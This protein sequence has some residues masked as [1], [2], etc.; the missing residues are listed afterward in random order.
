MK[1]NDGIHIR[2]ADIIYG[3][4]KHRFLIIVLTAAGLLTGVVLSGISYLRGEM[5]REYLIT[6][7]FS[8]NTQTQ[9]GLF[10]SGYDFPNYN[11]INMAE[12]L[13]DAVSYALK[14]DRMLN[15]IIDSL[16]LLG[17]TTKDIEDNLELTQ[18]NETQIIEVFLYWRSSQ[19][20]ID[21]L[22]EMNS[23]APEILGEALG[24]GNVSVI[25]NPTARYMVGGRINMI[26]WGYMALLGLGLGIGIILL[27][28]IMRP[29]LIN[30]QDVEDVYGLEILCEV[31]EDKAYFR[32][33]K[34]MLVKE[35]VNSDTGENFASAAHIIQTRLRK[36]EG[37]HI[38]YITSTLRGEGKTKM[39]ANLAI[40][41]SDLEKHVLLI[42]FDMKNP[43]LGGLFL[44]NVEYEH[45]LN[46]LY[47]GDINEKEAVTT[48]TGYLDIL[49]T[50]LERSAIP[51]D[52]NL[53]TVIQKLAAG[54]DYVL[55]DTA[56]VGL[57][58]DP[59]SLNQ[60]ATAALFVVHYDTASMQEIKDALERIEKSGVS[61]LGCI[62]NGV[63]VSERGIKN[64]VT[65]NERVKNAQRKDDNQSAPTVNF[66]QSTDY[67]GNEGDIGRTS[68]VAGFAGE[69]HIQAEDDAPEVTTSSSFVELLFQA[70]NNGMADDETGTQQ[71]ADTP[72]WTAYEQ[73]AGTFSGY[74]E[75]EGSREQEADNTEE[76]DDAKEPDDTEEWS[77]S[78][79]FTDG[80]EPME[81]EEPA[82]SEGPV[83]SE[84]VMEPEEPVESEKSVKTE[85]AAGQ[86]YAEKASDSIDQ[87]QK[88]MEELLR[89]LENL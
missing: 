86:G 82:E 64:P 23:R 21:I 63:K 29:T 69:E 27:E 48:L 70:E 75:A 20:G 1:N 15:E 72:V 54:Y 66:E 67:V 56:P 22:T 39:L 28:L 13:V 31:A 89:T 44:K 38:I 5:S 57:T 33:G 40:Q 47:A 12:D 25:N 35:E 73:S 59:M 61:I 14:S 84:V 36:K 77:V 19:E 71:A 9:S 7:S 6:S 68:L 46:A 37:P 76:S 53:F 8:V 58:A 79:M 17:V 30:V 24:I 42:D 43:N 55:I 81:A 2:V 87:T 52:S 62:V 3:V 65:E 60:I 88:R 83:E 51:L 18:Y 26:L 16:G 11:D 34:S 85:E 41:L 49:P 4:I 32:Q 50:V 80:E 78:G 74:E 45:S 10:T